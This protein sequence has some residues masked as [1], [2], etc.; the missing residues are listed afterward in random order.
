MGRQPTIAIDGRLLGYRRGGIARYIESLTRALA[1]HLARCE[2][3]FPATFRV[4]ANR[5]LSAPAFP[6]LRCWTPPHHGLEHWTL[7]WE[8]VRHRVALFHATDFV[9]PWLPR[10]VRCVVTIHDLAFLDA[11]DEL[12]PAAL[13][14]YS[15][16]LASADR[17]DV[18][19]T[20]SQYTAMRLL[21]YRPHLSDRLRVVYHG[22]DHRWF[23]PLPHARDLARAALGDLG[24]RPLLL[25]VGT[26]E[27]RKGYDL[28]LDALRIVR[29]WLDPP[30]LLVVVG[31]RGW[32]T[33]HLEARLQQ[34]EAQGWL[35]WLTDVDD[36][37]LRALYATSTLLVVAS[38]DEGFCFPAAEALAAGLPVVAFAVGALPEVLADVGFLV[39]QRTAEAL[40]EAIYTLVEDE[41]RRATLAQAGKRRAQCFSWQRAAEETLQVYREALSDVR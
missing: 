31:Q 15:R 21:E 29:D 5:G 26:I 19:I 14:Y 6:V 30:P 8:L 32:K 2:Q 18:V 39:Y 28:L 11:P 9:L 7:G 38:R 16:T 25:A 22:I 40:A 36:D 34:A 10:S 1:H 12:D 13:R 20:V 41:A 37:L 24:E 17:A 4:L 33:E 27:P 3:P 23:G 35:R